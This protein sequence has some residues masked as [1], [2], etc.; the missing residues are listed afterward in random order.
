[1]EDRVG[2]RRAAM[3]GRGVVAEQRG[4]P[5]RAGR[6]QTGPR[7]RHR[8]AIEGTPSTE[9]FMRWVERVIWATTRASAKAG[10]ATSSRPSKAS[11]T[12]DLPSDQKTAE[13]KGFLTFG[14]CQLTRLLIK[15]RIKGEEL[16]SRYPR[17]A[18]SSGSLLANADN[19]VR[20]AVGLH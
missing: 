3:D 12:T 5:E 4:G 6:R 14:P 16:V 13:F 7:R 17:G 8:P 15:N 18:V 2:Q 19:C 9:T 10:T 20:R 11:S 1:E